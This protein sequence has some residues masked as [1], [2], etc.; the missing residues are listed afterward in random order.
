MIIMKNFTIHRSQFIDKPRDIVYSFFSNPEN[1]ECITPP[2]LHFK[3]MNTL[4]VSMD[5][6]QIINYKLKIRGI[7]IKWS[8]SNILKIAASVTLII[9]IGYL[10]FLF[11]NCLKTLKESLIL[12]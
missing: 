12:E 11:I 6:G 9:G 1:L 5:K 4:P 3:I 2:Y 10:S 7:S 8:S